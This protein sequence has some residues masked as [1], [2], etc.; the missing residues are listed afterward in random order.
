MSVQAQVL[1]LLK[2]LQDALGLGYLFISHN[3]A[4]V[5]YMCD[6][7]LV[8]CAGRIV[9]SAPRERLFEDARHPYT[10]ALIAAVPE[11]DPDRPLDFAAL[12]DGRASDPAAWPEPWRL[13]PGG[14][15]VMDEVTPGHFVRVAASAEAAA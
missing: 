10:K 14:P 8:M 1:N 7:I 15:S 2:D 3:L 13:A 12:M 6:R 5:D 9:E 4:V 11:A